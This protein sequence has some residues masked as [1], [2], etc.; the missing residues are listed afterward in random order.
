LFGFGCLTEYRPRRPG[1]TE[2][3]YRLRDE[4]V[5]RGL[6]GCLDGLNYD[7]WVGRIGRTGVAQCGFVPGRYSLGYSLPV[8]PLFG[9]ALPAGRKHGAVELVFQADCPV[10]CPFVLQSDRHERHPA[11]SPRGPVEFHRRLWRALPDKLR[12][13]CVSAADDWSVK[14]LSR[15][16]H[17]VETAGIVDD[18]CLE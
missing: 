12:E 1:V 8:P 16:L 7:R 3:A 15:H 18:G 10:S 17:R 4:L 5:V 14:A 6:P 11:G 2:L 13:G 9:F